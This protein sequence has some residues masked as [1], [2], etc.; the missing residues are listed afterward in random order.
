MSRR[1]SS[2]RFALARSPRGLPRRIPR[3]EEGTIKLKKAAKRA[4]MR[5]CGRRCVY[6]AEPLELDLAT[7]DHVYPLSKGGSHAHGNLVAACARC[8]RLKGDM[9]PQVFFARFPWAGANFIRYA[10]TV[11]RA[12]KRGARRAVS[13]AYARQDAA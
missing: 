8:N 2:Q 7:I 6:C 4:A 10:R 11:H 1:R 13:L 12:L 3:P 9:L 5:D